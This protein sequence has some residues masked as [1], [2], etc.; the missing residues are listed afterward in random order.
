[1]DWRRIPWTKDGALMR[2]RRFTSGVSLRKWR[3][4]L[5][6]AIRMMSWKL[7][8][9]THSGARPADRRLRQVPLEWNFPSTNKTVKVEMTN[10]CGQEPLRTSSLELH[11]SLLGCQPAACVCSE[12]ET[13]ENTHCQEAKLPGHR[14]DK[15]KQEPS[16]GG[17]YKMYYS[18]SS[19]DSL[20]PRN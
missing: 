19:S 18:K 1:M 11:R 4:S 20:H 2:S 9:V 5:S 7:S 14:A 17:M 12:A 3:P 13:R 15:G 10:A 6:L 8:L 16:L